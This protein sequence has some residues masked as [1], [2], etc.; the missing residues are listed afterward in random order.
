MVFLHSVTVSNN[1]LVFLLAVANTILTPVIVVVL[2]GF[3]VFITNPMYFI[4]LYGPY[5]WSIYDVSFTYLAYVFLR[6]DGE[7][8]KKVIGSLRDRLLLSISII[9]GLVSISFIL[10]YISSLMF[11]GDNL[12]YYT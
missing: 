9:I 1:K 4:F 12:H 10:S 3:E 7:D 6:S 5:L 2:I 11:G 8:V